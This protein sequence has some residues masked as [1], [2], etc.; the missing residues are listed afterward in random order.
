MKKIVFSHIHTW[1]LIFWAIVMATTIATFL[2]LYGEINSVV[3]TMIMEQVAEEETSSNTAS[4]IHMTEQRLAGLKIRIILLLSGGLFVIG[5]L[6]FLWMRMASRGLARPVRILSNA[7]S[8]LSRGKLN[9][10]VTLETT[11]EFSQ[12]ATGINELAANLQ[13]LL[14]YIWKQTGQC[15]EKIEH[16]ENSSGSENQHQL[17]SESLEHIKL[18]NKAVHDLREMAKA[19]V[20][21]DVYLDGDKTLAINDPDN[22][23]ANDSQ[24]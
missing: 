15:L 9:E 22:S 1:L 24:E 23:S 6:G 16:L 7:L 4:G 5:G 20:F 11:D 10:T 2:L 19:Y 18:L 12:I 21:Y 13:E 14:L 3:S 8:R 17:P